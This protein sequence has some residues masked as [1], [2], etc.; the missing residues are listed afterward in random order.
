MAKRKSEKRKRFFFYI[1]YF[2]N[3]EDLSD[4][5]VRG[6][7]GAMVAVAQGE[8]P[9]ELSGEAKGLFRMIRG[10]MERDMESYD[11]FCE[12]QS[13][14]GKKGGRPRKN[15]ES[16]ASEADE[17]KPWV[18]QKAEKADT[19]TEADTETEAEADAETET[20]TALSG[21]LG[22]VSAHGA[23]A[24]P[25]P[26]EHN[27]LLSLGQAGRGELSDLPE[28]EIST[29]SRSEQ[30][31]YLDWLAEDDCDLPQDD[32]ELPE[33][34]RD[35]PQ[36]DR[37]LPEPPP[38]FE[39]ADIPPELP[40]WMAPDWDEPVPE[41]VKEPE[42]PF[43]RPAGGRGRPTLAQIEAHCRKT[44]SPVDPKR[45]F[46]YY[47]AKGWRMNGEPIRN[48]KSALRF[49]GL[50]ERQPV[51]QPKTTSYDAEAFDRLGLELPPF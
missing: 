33:D 34:D 10:Q 47:E 12:I 24:G 6:L 5:D 51:H 50:T 15:A 3:M 19:D 40:D 32:W 42:K 25:A 18:F 17:K 41:P 22:R 7:L 30:A 2:E 45:F 14:R 37:E 23:H 9:A 39:P 27:G 20:E 48:W 36:D 44:K 31:A 13:D 8:E 4:G 43:V 1:D 26:A 49:W 46:E 38:E 11:K 28:C 16:A 35:L 29:K 21:E